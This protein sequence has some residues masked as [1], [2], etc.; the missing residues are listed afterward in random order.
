MKIFSYRLLLF[1]IIYLFIGGLIRYFLPYHWGNPWYSTKIRHLESLEKNNYNTLFFGSSKTYRQINPL[2]FDEKVNLLIPNQQIKSFN[3]GAPA[4]FPPQTYY[5]LENFLKSPLALNV[6]YVFLEL[7]E[8]RNIGNYVL[9]EERTNYWVTQK[10]FLFSLSSFLHKSDISI[11]VKASAV[12]NF[13]ISYIENIFH[14]GH[15]TSSL[16]KKNYYKKIYLGQ[17][18]NGFY[19]LEQDLID[20]E[21][22]ENNKICK[23][24]RLDLNNSE[25][26][27][28]LVLSE[29]LKINNP[30]AHFNKINHSRILSLTHLCEKNNIELI[31]IIPPRQ[32]VQSIRRLSKIL[33]NQIIDMSDPREFP[34]L[35]QKTNSF[36]VAHLNNK[37]AKL[38]SKLLA[39][40]W[41]SKRL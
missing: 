36:D 29:S 28:N 10:E 27:K 38:Y 16:A 26:L 11:K 25:I 13:T 40:K 12:K 5:L 34:A 14:L 37:G 19:S 3:L 6:K 15:F 7:D 24:R 8:V 4:T 33:P 17:I 9:H 30:V 2:I 18:Q 1:L 22:E 39:K 23:Q 41:L 32:T 20:S 31:L 35:Y 21:N